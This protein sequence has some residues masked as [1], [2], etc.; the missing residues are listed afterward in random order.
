VNNSINEV[1]VGEVVTYPRSKR[2]EKDW[3]SEYMKYS[4]MKKHPNREYFKRERE[5]TKRKYLQSLN[6]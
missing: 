2:I 1:L 3:I 5:E 6:K 4:R